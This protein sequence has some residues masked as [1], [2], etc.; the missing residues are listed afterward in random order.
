MDMMTEL[1]LLNSKGMVDAFEYVKSQK[2]LWD[3]KMHIFNVLN[4]ANEL[5]RW[6]KE[7]FEEIFKIANVHLY[8]SIVG[9]YNKVIRFNIDWIDGKNH[10]HD[11]PEFHPH[12]GVL[13]DLCE[14][15]KLFNPSY[16]KFPFKEIISLNDNITEKVLSVMLSDE[17][18]AILDYNQMQLELDRPKKENTK[19]AKM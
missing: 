5:E 15:F 1:N 12:Y 13:H 2:E 17:L 6:K 7:N 16:V 4:L 10:Y 11:T 14:Q 18:S 19:K 8:D 9:D 3:K